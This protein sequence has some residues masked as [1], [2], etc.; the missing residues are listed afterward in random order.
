M[1]RH[2]NA[3]IY[4]YLK[5]SLGYNSLVVNHVVYDCLGISALVDRVSKS[6]VTIAVDGSLYRYHPK[7]HH[8]ITEKVATLSPNK[9]VSF[10][11]VW[12]FHD[13]T[14]LFNE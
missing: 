8:L 13:A 14:V 2:C 5:S 12:L 3:D 4:N 11:Q 6:D 1:A 7:F 9:K 10:H